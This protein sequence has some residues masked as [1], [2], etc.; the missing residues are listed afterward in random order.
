[1]LRRDAKHGQLNRVLKAV[2]TSLTSALGVTSAPMLP[3]WWC[4]S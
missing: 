3:S 1:M 2:H 4:W